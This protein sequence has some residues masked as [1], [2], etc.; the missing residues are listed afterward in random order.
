M[1]KKKISI[2][3]I[4][5][6]LSLQKKIN[7]AIVITF[8]FIVIIFSSI[9][10]PFQQRRMNTVMGKVRILL[11]TLVDRDLNYLANEIF[12]KR[13]RAIEL[14]VKQM[15]EVEGVL[16]INVYDG[17]G[18]LLASDSSREKQLSIP[19]GEIQNYQNNILIE[20]RKW[21]RKNVLHYIQEIIVSGD[22]IG[23]I[24]IFFSLED[25]EFEQTLSTILYSGLLVL[26]LIIML[27]LLNYI[28]K[29]AIIQPLTTLRD[30]MEY[31]EIS[32]LGKQLEILSNDEIGEL[33]ASFNEMSLELASSVAKKKEI[34]NELRNTKDYLQTVLN[35]LQSMLISTDSNGYVTQWNTAAK[36]FTGIHIRDTINKKVWEL[37]PFLKNYKNRIIQLSHSGNDDLYGISDL[38]EYENSYFNV[39]FFSMEY[40]GS[41]GIVIRIDDI[42]ELQKKDEQLRQIQKMETI[43]NLAGGLAHDFNNAL[44]GIIGTL[45]IMRYKMKKNG[46]IEKVKFDDYAT[47]IEDSGKRASDMVQR[48][49]SLSRKQDLKFE[50]V[51]LNSS[52]RNVVK[53]CGNTFDKAIEIIP[54]YTNDSSFV[55]ADSTQIEQILLNLCINASHAMTIM[56]KKGEPLGGK[57]TIS[58]TDYTPDEDFFT[59]NQDLKRNNYWKISIRDTG[60]GMDEKT[61]DKIFDPFFTTK[62][63][64]E[65]TVL[66]L[67][68]VY[69]I[70]QQHNG[71]ID[72]DSKIGVGTEFCI[73]IPVLAGRILSSDNEYTTDIYEGSGSIL[74]IDDEELLRKTASNILEECGY[75]VFCAETG[76]EGIEILQRKSNEINVVLLDIIIPKLSARETYLKLKEINPE[77]KVIL[78]SSIKEDARVKKLL[79]LGAND[80][81]KKPYNLIN[82]SKSVFNIIYS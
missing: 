19:I 31:M 32:D 38:F 42:T 25:V 30:Q 23:Y 43:G 81:L 33:S 13:D 35:S 74:V 58:I 73:Y 8:I 72:V 71:V 53:I 7:S 65:G 44:S 52:I 46:K 12:E 39:D 37:L 63:A 41:K 18:N 57:L 17:S 64:V 15:L 16:S 29:K 66:G 75:N 1:K 36:K 69:N 14:R 67:S 21:N 40:E 27:F 5:K 26:I 4:I 59:N 2:K 61:V 34:E 10:F 76:L 48:L 55:K 47:V 60:I 54:Q 51:D 70:I 78:V 62:R 6:N 82:L 79:S 11:E 49:L 80:F 28:L 45:S 3:I 56:R 22:G 24:Q 9:Q 20:K 77:I 68:M 50:S